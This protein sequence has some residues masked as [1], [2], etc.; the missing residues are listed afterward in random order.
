[1]TIWDDPELKRPGNFVSFDNKGDEIVG[2]IIHVGKHRFDDKV[3]P[4]IILD[5]DGEER[6]VTAGQVQLQTKLAELRPVEGDRIKI[7]LTEI[8]KRAGG[9]TLKHFDV[10]VQKGVAPVAPKPAD[11]DPF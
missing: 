1:M 9:K 10:K 3:V 4:Q 5:C 8:E 7:T 6:T 11:E 2:N